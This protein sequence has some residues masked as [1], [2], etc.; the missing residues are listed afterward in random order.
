MKRIPLPKLP[1]PILIIILASLS[2]SLSASSLAG[3]EQAGGYATGDVLIGPQVPLDESFRMTLRGGY[4]AAGVGMRNVGGG[5]IT[6]DLPADSTIAKAFLY[7]AVIRQPTQP[8]LNTGTLNG[9]GIAG[10][11]IGTTGDPC[12]PFFLSGNLTDVYRADVTALA[13]DGANGLTVFPSGLTDHTPPQ[14]APSAFPLLEGASLVV[15]FENPGFDLNTVV[16]RDGAQSFANQSLSTAF[17]SFNPGAAPA[18]QVAQTTYIVGDGQARFAGDRAAFNGA[19]VA[20]PGTGLKPADAFDGADGIAS[21]FPLDGL[22]DTLTVDVSSFFPPGTLTPASAAVDASGSSDCLTWCVQA[23]SVKTSPSVQITVADIV[24][25]RIEVELQP[26]SLSGPLV[27]TLVGDTNV[28]LFEG[29]Q[30]GGTRTFSFN[31]DTLPEGQYREVRAA[32]TVLGVT[33]RGT[34]PVAFRVLG[35]YRHSQ[36]NTPDESACAGGPAPAFIFSS[37]PPSCDF[38]E[39][40]LRAMFIPRV[41]LN[42]SGRSIDFGDVV[43]ENLCLRRENNP[44]PGSAMRSFRQEAILGACRIGVGDTTVARTPNHPFLGCG[45]QVLI[46]GLGAR[47]GTVKTVTDLC[48]GCPERQLDNYTT[49]PACA[50]PAVRDLGRFVTIR[51]R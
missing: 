46:V 49:V 2:G 27:L 13:V 10:T 8:P 31:P 15:I 14:D 16:I 3:D 35:T 29:V 37:G 26:T 22:W 18:G 51:L 39:T 40:I 25:D 44:P 42:G 11:P 50:P 6:V 7:W 20:G 4:V 45:D 33:A 30:E 36:Y 9:I 34:R 47:P 41:N 43:V 21:V 38:T 24:S 32:W 12:W 19:S 5:T 28:T 1:W 48:P 17:G 23:L